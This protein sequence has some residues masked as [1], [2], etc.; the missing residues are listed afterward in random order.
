MASM[1]GGKVNGCNATIDM[2]GQHA[3]CAKVYDHTGKHQTIILLADYG[4]VTVQWLQ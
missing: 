3:L 1:R 2:E 4:I